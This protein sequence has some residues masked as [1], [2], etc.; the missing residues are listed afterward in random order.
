M[1][2]KHGMSHGESGSGAGGGVTRG[3]PRAWRVM[4]AFA[5]VVAMTLGMAC[6]APAANAAD[7]TDANWSSL[8]STLKRSTYGFFLWRAENGST[9]NERDTARDATNILLNSALPKTKITGKTG[10][11]TS[12]DNA[13]KAAKALVK[14]NEYRRSLPNEPCRTDLAEG[15]GRACDSALRTLTPYL[16]SDTFM[17][18]T[19]VNA[20]YSDGV[21]DH[22]ANNGQSIPSIYLTGTYENLA[23][24][25][26]TLNSNETPRAASQ[27]YSEKSLYDSGTTDSSAIGHYTTLTNK[28]GF[29][30][31][32]NFKIAGFGFNTV[33]TRY[34]ATEVLDCLP[35]SAW[36]TYTGYTQTAAAYLADL[37]AYEKLVPVIVSV[38]NPADVTTKSGTAP[39]LPATVKATLS[40]GS[41]IDAPVTWNSYDPSQYKTIDANT[42]TVQG[43]VP[44]WSK[45]VTV[46]VKVTPATVTSVAGSAVSTTEEVAPKLPATVQ[47]CYSN[48]QCMQRPVTWSPI[49]ASQYASPG[50][51]TVTGTVPS[52][53]NTTAKALVTVKAATITSIAY[54]AD[55]TTVQ[56]VAPK[57]PSTVK[58]TLNNGKTKD[59]PVVWA[60]VSSDKYAKAGTSFTVKG[61]VSGYANPVT[62][63]VRVTAPTITSLDTVAVVTKSG[64]KPSLP[65]TVTAHYN[66]GTTAQVPVTWA[67]IPSS[68]YSKRSGGVFT[69]NGSVKGTSIKAVAK[70]VVSPAFATSATTTVAVTTT[71][72]VAPKLPSTVQVVWSNGDKTQEAVV[73]NAVKASSYARKGTFSV[74]GRFTNAALAVRFGALTA[75][76]KVNAAAEQR[77]YRLYNPNSGEHFYTAAVAERDHLVTL[78]WH[79]EGIGWIAPVKSGTPVYRMYNP[80]AGDHHYTMSAAERDMLIGKGWNYEGIG[81]YSAENAGRAPLYRQYNPNAKAGA[82]N[83]TLNPAE[84][85]N[86]VRLGWHDEGTA[87]YAVRGIQ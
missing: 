53:S 55:V 52:A 11:A 10:S 86:L 60:P 36:S 75:N 1:D 29:G 42:F 83:F 18:I 23:W 9:Q 17:A 5:A 49:A 47:V 87:W 39:A 71:E 14:I 58:A 73:W 38:R 19:Q 57:L 3:M 25:W 41:V 84:R 26:D 80:N 56:G 30:S 64:T 45:P 7:P 37:Q 67:S 2:E 40:S 76:V 82:H 4:V 77:M 70:V 51:F 12:L 50:V 61:A 35:D 63:T 8:P 54:P 27:W 6:A 22:A 24:N 79:D 16:T 34:G 85:D 31:Y 46:K 65:R 48:G 32:Q 59:V 78:G 13:I 62:V 66:N 15:K 68:Y 74:N 33:G 72:G 43:T 20:D 28:S 81:W 69:V 44:E 21:I